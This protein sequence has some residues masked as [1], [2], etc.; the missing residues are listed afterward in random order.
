[1]RCCEVLEAR[2][3]ELEQVI[4]REGVRRR[5]EATESW[6]KRA[7]EKEF[8]GP[9]PATY[10]R[11]EL[12]PAAKYWQARSAEAESELD[13]LKLESSERHSE[14]RRNIERLE[15]R[16]EHLEGVI[17]RKD[18]HFEERTTVL[19]EQARDTEVRLGDARRA[20]A[21]FERELVEQTRDVQRLVDVVREWPDAT[22]G[23]ALTSRHRVA[24]RAALTPFVGEPGPFRCGRNTPEG[25]TGPGSLR[26]GTGWH[27]TALGDKR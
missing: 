10:E 17:R 13:E 27:G 20:A 19:K 1:M 2:V 7:L 3:T 5:G 22:P 24:L 9:V 23:V 21:R 4:A 16:V 12:E 11:K 6:V 14:D 25:G 15:R 26:V 8:A 18:D